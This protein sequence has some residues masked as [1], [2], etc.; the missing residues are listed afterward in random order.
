MLQQ[1]ED[2][3]FRGGK[4]KKKLCCARGPDL[5]NPGQDGIPQDV[6]IQ[7][8]SFDAIQ[9][10]WLDEVVELPT[11]FATPV[12]SFAELCPSRTTIDDITVVLR[13]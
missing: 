6:R 8:Q 3:R 7:Q 12:L 13:L 2:S 11:C 1:G 5:F 4:G 9:I 10:N